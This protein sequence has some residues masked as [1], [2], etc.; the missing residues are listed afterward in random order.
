M[1]L[2][3]LLASLDSELRSD[4]A[5]AERLRNL[6]AAAAPTDQ[7]QA[8]RVTA[9]AI[10]DQI[11]A[12]D[13][14]ASRITT[15]ATLIAGE[16]IA[17]DGALS[18][19][20]AEVDTLRALADV[21]PPSPTGASQAALGLSQELG[22]R[23][24]D[25]RSITALAPREAP[26]D[27]PDPAAWRGTAPSGLPFWAGVFK[28]QDDMV[29]LME[30]TRF[31]NGGSL[32]VVLDYDA[33]A[34]TFGR[35]AATTIKAW[36]PGSAHRYLTTGRARCF[37]WTAHPFTG[38]SFFDVPA[39]WSDSV[40]P[41][42]FLCPNRPPTFTGNETA[43]ER[44]EK[45]LRVWKMAADG[46]LDAVWRSYLVAMKRDYFLRYKLTG[47]RIVFRVAH[48]LDLV[49]VW[50]N[51]NS[52]RCNSVGFLTSA[53]DMAVVRR[54]LG[55]YLDLFLA[56]FGQPQPD[57][58]GDVGWPVDELWTMFN[59]V[60]EAF[61]PLGA[62]ICDACPDNAYIVGP[63]YYDRYPPNLDAKAFAS[64]IARV[65]LPTAAAANPR[66]SRGLAWWRDWCKAKGKIFGVPEWGVWSET[67]QEDGV[68]RPSHE[69]WDNPVF[70]ERMLSF[71]ADSADMI[72]PVAYFNTDFVKDVNF[73]GN[74]IATWPGIDD[75]T[76]PCART[77][78]GDVNRCASRAF[79]EWMKTR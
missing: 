76:A 60:K 20:R 30:G 11:V 5:D 43:L 39:A 9:A 71:F 23:L 70:V 15:A 72:G 12:L 42:T 14:K 8:L 67:I 49:P 16:A 31:A 7:S 78:I 10:A 4:R 58:G 17:I 33:P 3:S 2:R 48:E 50:G 73:P 59:P 29:G 77:P 56:V 44:R 66:W 38:G 53:A 54:A 25:L 68:S 19:L 6:I 28:G 13:A 61:L 35:K 74:R 52:P 24:T 1:S 26:Y 46:A 37:I 69:G 18:E 34:P 55:R 47:V 65:V 75:P 62:D 57:I 27:R 79:R 51:T 41:E 21:P 64:N 22:N 45:Q 36:E 63:D 32:D 40:T